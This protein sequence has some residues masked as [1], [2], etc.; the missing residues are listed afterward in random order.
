MYLGDYIYEYIE[1]RHPT[2]RQHSDGVEATTLPTYRNRYAQYPHRS[3]PAA[4]AARPRR[5]D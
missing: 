5:Q 3:R 1:K 4:A 2:V